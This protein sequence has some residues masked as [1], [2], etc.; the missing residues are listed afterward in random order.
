MDECIKCVV[1]IIQ[2]NIIQHK[3]NAIL[4]FETT[5]MELEGFKLSEISQKEKDKYIISLIC[6]TLPLPPERKK[7]TSS[8]LQIQKNDW[9][10]QWW[11][12]G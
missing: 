2:W 3:K 5:C 12:T 10:Y 6:G 9:W 4:S 7:K 11:V 8:Y 1:Y